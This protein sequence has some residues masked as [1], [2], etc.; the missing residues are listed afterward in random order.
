MNEFYFYYAEN[1]N[2]YAEFKASQLG[3]LLNQISIKATFLM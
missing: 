2:I 3:N 1:S